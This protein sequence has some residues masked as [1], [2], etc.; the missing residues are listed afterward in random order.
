MNFKLLIL[1]TIAATV[2]TGS[3]DAQNESLNNGEPVMETLTAGDGTS[4]PSKGAQVSAHYRGTLMD[5]T[6]FD[7]SYKRGQPFSFKLGVGQVIRCWDFALSRMSVG[8]KVKVTCPADWAYGSRGAGG[9]IPPNADL[10]FDV[11]LVSFN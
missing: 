4:F 9:V 6:E 2:L 5:G 10:I 3:T 1:I 8:Q 7:S 11:E